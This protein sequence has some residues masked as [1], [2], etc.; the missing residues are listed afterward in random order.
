MIIV[1]LWLSGIKLF[2]IFFKGFCN[3]F[4]MLNPNIV[5]DLNYVGSPHSIVP[6]M[7]D[8]NIIVSKFKL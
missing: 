2:S 5:V 8:C 1:L 7:L 3:L 4:I 6:D